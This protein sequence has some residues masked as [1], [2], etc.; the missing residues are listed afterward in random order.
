MNKIP[1]DSSFELYPGETFLCRLPNNLAS[2]RLVVSKTQ[3]DKWSVAVAITD[4][5][6]KQTKIKQQECKT[7]NVFIGYYSSAEDE[8]RYP[9]INL[10]SLIDKDKYGF[11]LGEYLL[12]LQ[13]LNKEY[14]QITPKLN[15]TLE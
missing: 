6:T 9:G 15:C 2:L 8:K 5:V 7:P 14:I 11:F 4:E 13:L 1:G 12:R 3:D 10:A